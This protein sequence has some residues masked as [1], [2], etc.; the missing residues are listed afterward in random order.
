MGKINWND[1]QARAAEMEARQ[2]SSSPR[3]G[4]FTLKNDGD[5]AIV[6]IMHDTP[7]EFDILAVH[8]TQVDG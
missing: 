5:E 8:Q 2:A 7:E 1:F 3:V 6:R 4:F